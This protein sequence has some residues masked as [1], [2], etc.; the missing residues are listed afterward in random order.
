MKREATNWEKMFAN[1]VSVERLISKIYE[2]LI[3]L[4]SK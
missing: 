4:N 2:V 3:Q 1:H